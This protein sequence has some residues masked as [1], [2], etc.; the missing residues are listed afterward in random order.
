M[1]YAKT[2]NLQVSDQFLAHTLTICAMDPLVYNEIGVLRYLQVCPCLIQYSPSVVPALSHGPLSL[3]PG[4][5][6]QRLHGAPVW[7]GKGGRT[8]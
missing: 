2:G 5:L 4:L 3:S 8:D 7:E 1:E 6:P